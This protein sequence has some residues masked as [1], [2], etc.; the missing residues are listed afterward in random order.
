MGTSRVAGFKV[1]SGR[2]VD[3]TIA[4]G[5]NATNGR[6]IGST[7][8]AGFDVSTGRPVGTT[9]DAGFDAS[10]GRPVGTTHDAGF[11]VSDGR[12]LGTTHDNG[13]KSSLIEDNAPELTEH[14]KQYDLPI[15]WN[16]NGECLSLNDEL[17]NRGRK[18]IGQQVRFDSKPLGIGMCYC[19]GSILWS[20]V[21]NS[22]TSLVTVDIEEENIPALAYQKVMCHNNNK[23]SVLQY[24]HKSG[25]LY[26]CTVCKSFKSPSE[27]TSELHVGKIKTDGLIL[28]VHE[29]DMG[30]PQEILLLKNQTEC[31][32][33]SL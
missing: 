18:C 9:L 22:H 8:D 33:V 6:K 15:M 29:W 31:C 25:K 17:L 32:Q 4:A 30:Y 11:N 10:T 16:T 12:P 21:D 7:R 3:T 1:S 13:A 2:P 19:C 24:R 26:A 27:F 5:F 20:R 14:I 28:P 23:E